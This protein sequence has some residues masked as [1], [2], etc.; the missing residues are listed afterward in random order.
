M[1]VDHKVSS[2]SKVMKMLSDY[3]FD[4]L[5][6]S[7]TWLTVSFSSELVYAEGYYHLVRNGRVFRGGEM[8]FLISAGI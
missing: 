7:E 6:L 5:A 1:K 2:H 8:Y 3:N 4:I